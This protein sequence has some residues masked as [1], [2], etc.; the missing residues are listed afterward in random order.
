MPV[1]SPNEKFLSV[2]NALTNGLMGTI[3][4]LNVA[5]NGSLTEVAGS[6]FANPGGSI[7]SGLSTDAAGKFLFA[8]N[9]SGAV[10]VFSV[11]ANGAIAPVAG[12]PVFTGQPG[13][14]SLAL[15]PGRSCNAAATCIR[16]NTTGDVFSFNALTGTYRYT[17]CSDGFSIS[18]NG[19]VR[20]VGGILSLT[21]NKPDRRIS[22]SFL[23]GQLTGNATVM[24]SMAPGIWQTIMLHDTTSFGTVCS[25]SM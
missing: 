24:I 15:F 22:A 21:D 10:S 23:T 11:A 19:V 13:M 12:S 8:A 9:I 1:L 14:F 3:T 2:S 5:S 4:V 6:P 7:P 18:G 25:C 16:D 17:R 20:S